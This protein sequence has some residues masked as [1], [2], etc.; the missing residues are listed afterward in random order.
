[1]KKKAESI[2]AGCGTRVKS[3]TRQKRKYCDRCLSE[4]KAIHNKARTDPS[5]RVERVCEICGKPF[6]MYKSH[7]K[8]QRKAGRF[9]SD[10]CRKKW[11]SGFAMSLCENTL[12]KDHMYDSS[13]QKQFSVPAT[14]LCEAGVGHH[15]AKSGKLVSP[16]GE[17]YH[18]TN[19]RHFVRNNERLFTSECVVWRK[20]C[21]DK[22][23]RIKAGGSTVGSLTCLATKGL[24][25]V[26]SSEVKSWH[27]W[28][29]GYI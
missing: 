29:G 16:Q 21:V 23:R 27:G 11:V 22:R 9:C 12:H 19:V 8:D 26:L 4:S 17:T 3:K 5:N 1:M 28:T 20:K 18:I 10:G 24:Q 13:A 6:S 14:G 15:A 2:C 7:L 25:R